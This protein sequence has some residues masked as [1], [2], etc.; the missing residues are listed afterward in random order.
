M[1]DVAIPPRCKTEHGKSKSAGKKE[2]ADGKELE[3][4]R[5]KLV[6]F[7]CFSVSFF[8]LWVIG[9]KLG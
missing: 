4:C 7:R 3:G 9:Q 1:I 8:C 5:Q 2:M 6:F